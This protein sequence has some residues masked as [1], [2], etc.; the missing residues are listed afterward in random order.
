LDT[1]PW[2]GQDNTPSDLQPTVIFPR[3][4][5]TVEVANRWKGFS[6]KHLRE[7][8]LSQALL[9]GGRYAINYAKGVLAVVASNGHFDKAPVCAVFAPRAGRVGISQK[10]LEKFGHNLKIS[11]HLQ[12]ISRRNPLP[13]LHLQQSE[14]NSLANRPP[15]LLFWNLVIEDIYIRMQ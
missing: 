1:P 4:E 13:L 11:E 7:Q 9:R 5:I 3:G 8:V 10:N 6:A 2:R 12:K 14:K 15:L